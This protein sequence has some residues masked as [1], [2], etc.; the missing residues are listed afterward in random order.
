MSDDARVLWEA[1]GGDQW[2]ARPSAPAVIVGCAVW[3]VLA[4]VAVAVVAGVVAV[5]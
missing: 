4:A 3:V 5:L 1:G 2:E